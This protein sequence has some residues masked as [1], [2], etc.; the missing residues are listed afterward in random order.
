MCYFITVIYT[1]N[2]TFNR[3]ACTN[4]L[5]V[6]SVHIINMVNVVCRSSNGLKRELIVHGCMLMDS[7]YR[8]D[9]VIV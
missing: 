2:P 9:G 6:T 7:C 1:L 5:T 4:G 8:D 3:N